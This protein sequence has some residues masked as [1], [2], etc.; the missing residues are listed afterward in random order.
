MFREATGYIITFLV[1]LITRIHGQQL[2]PE[3]C[4][5]G[6]SSSI[7]NPR[8]HAVPARFELIGEVNDGKETIEFSQAFSLTRDAI[9]TNSK[10][11]TICSTQL[12]RLTPEWLFVL[13]A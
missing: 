12:V 3:L 5:L 6:P 13:F 9:A 2:D 11:G 4:P 8:W 7:P 10:E 1:V